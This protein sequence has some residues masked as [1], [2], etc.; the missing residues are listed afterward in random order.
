MTKVDQARAR[1]LGI[2]PITA[3]RYRGNSNYNSLQSKL[4][5]RFARGLSLLTSYTW[6]HAIDDSPGGICGNGA[7]ARDC[8]PDDPTRPELE[9]GNSDTDVRHRFTF[10]NV[11][12][13]PLGRGRRWGSDM[14]K[15]L[16]VAVGAMAIQ[17]HRRRGRVVRCSMSRATVA[18]WI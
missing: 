3:T 17:Q 6:A 1:V 5:K 10:A 4:E 7:G 9:R 18:A 15:A 13:F 11:W 12:D 2:G 16:D 14:P 8:G